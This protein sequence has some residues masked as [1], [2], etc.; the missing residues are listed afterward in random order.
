LKETEFVEIILNLTPEDCNG[1]LQ[2]HLNGRMS[3]ILHYYF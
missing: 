2:L 3:L 1:T